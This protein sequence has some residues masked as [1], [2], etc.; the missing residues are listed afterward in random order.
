M[1]FRRPSL[2]FVLATG[3]ALA[4]LVWMTFGDLQRFRAEAPAA[5]PTVDPLPRV[6]VRE[7]RQASYQPSLIAQGQ[8]MPWKE[9]ELRARASGQIETLPVAQG[10]AVEAGTPLLH[11]ALEDL[12]AQ[13][14]RAEAELELARA[15]LSGAE[16]LRERNLVSRTEQLRMASAVAEAV[17]EVESLR[18]TLSHTRPQAPF[19]GTLDRLDVEEG[20]VLQVG[21]PY[22]LLI[23]NQRLKA[24][25]YVAQRD[26]LDLSPGLPVRVRLL[27][28]SELAGELT[29]VAARADPSTRTFAIEAVVDN[30]ARRRLG[31][32]SATLDITL[33]ER[34]AHQLS[35]A[36]LVLD[37]MGRLGVKTL[38]ADDRVA[39]H[40]VSLVAMKPDHAWVAD[41]PEQVRLITLGGGF[42]EIG[43]RVEAV[44]VAPD[45]TPDEGSALA[46]GKLPG[47][48]GD[49]GER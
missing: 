11:L 6:E 9:V 47:A 43:E 26:V 12:P 31:G 16:R 8:L 29:H 22:A 34:Q 2:S 44:P 40:H 25:A 13:L 10:D 49:D 39:F 15:E 24:Q 18:Q 35:P 36:L 23:D 38:D 20:D 17:A 37:D 32:A 27:D 30:P 41:L 28:G 5:E 42:V 33:P 1:A 19:A 3:C 48:D 46:G 21:E 7:S 45:A 14:K 4:L